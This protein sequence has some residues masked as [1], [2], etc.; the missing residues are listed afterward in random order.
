MMME[1]LRRSGRLTGMNE[2]VHDESLSLTLESMAICCPILPVKAI[3]TSTLSWHFFT[4][5]PSPEHRRISMQ[6]LRVGTKC[7]TLHG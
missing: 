3:F 6:H 5:S 2:Q 7:S 1:S 4:G